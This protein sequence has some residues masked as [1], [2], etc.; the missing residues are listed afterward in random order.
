MIVGDFH[1]FRCVVKSIPAIIAP[2][3]IDGARYFP[4]SP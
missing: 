2:Q 4:I 1:F 3:A